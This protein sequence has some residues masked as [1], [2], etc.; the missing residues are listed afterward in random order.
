M[1]LPVFDTHA[2]MNYSTNSIYSQSVWDVVHYFWFIQE[3]QSVGYPTRPMELPEEE[4]IDALVD[5]FQRVRNTVWALA[6]RETFR[7]LYGVELTDAASVREADEGVRARIDD[8]T[9]PAH[10]LGKLNIRHVTVNVE[11]VHDF[12]HLPG[13]GV[14]LPRLPGLG[15]KRDQILN[16]VD[17]RQEAEKVKT[18]LFDEVTGIS[19]RGHRGMR[20]SLSGFDG[21]SQDLKVRAIREGEQL[22][23]GNLSR[24]DV[25][26]F[27]THANLEAL[28]RHNLFAQLFLGIGRPPGSRT[29]MAL[30]DP[31]RITDLFPLFE[32]YSCDF[33]LVSGSPA[34]N[35]DVVQPARIFPNVHAGALWWYNFRK[36][37]YAE[38]MQ[39]RMEAVPAEK[40]VILASDAREIDMVV[41]VSDLR[42]D[43]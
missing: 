20:V 7:V 8:P 4:R 32:R 41:G 18:T 21:R 28:S 15:K 29:A 26:A 14:A 24:G 33:E 6:V 17:P 25:D 39:V 42:E 43:C 9:W 22:P 3:L 1:D 13:V 5:A 23:T 27:L 35:M 34:H 40:S 16:A 12:P 19:R 11:A 37:S 2:H 30:N 10:V 36:S 38:A 31:D